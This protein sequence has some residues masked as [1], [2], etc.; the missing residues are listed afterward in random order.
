MEDIGVGE[1][2]TT[3]IDSEATLKGPDEGDLKTLSSSSNVPMLYNG[4]V[5]SVEHIK[6]IL[7]DTNFSGVVCG[8]FFVLNGKLRSPLI[9]YL[10]D[11]E[12]ASL[13]SDKIQ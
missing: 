11:D 6:S 8:A 3:F 1:I 5:G 10:S 9:S 4:G 2:I 12:M 7:H 13:I